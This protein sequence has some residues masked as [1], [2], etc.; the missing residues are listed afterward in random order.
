LPVFIL[1]L[2]IGAFLLCILLSFCY[3]PIGKLVNRIFKDAK[4][5]MSKDEIN[6]NEKDGK[7]N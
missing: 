2:F 5:S 6:E 7:E 4:D 1:L 3:I